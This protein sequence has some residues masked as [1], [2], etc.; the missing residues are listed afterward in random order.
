MKKTALIIGG[1]VAGISCALLLKKQNFDVHLF[2]R[3]ETLGGVT[4]YLHDS[5]FRF[6]KSAT[7][8]LFFERYAQFAAH[9]QTDLH[10]IAPYDTLD[11]TL[12]VYHASSKITLTNSRFEQIE[13][14]AKN[15]NKETSEEWNRF[16]TDYIR[17][18]NKL[19]PLIFSQ[20]FSQWKQVFSRPMLH[21]LR[22]HKPWKSVEQ[23][24]ATYNMH[25]CV[26]N[27]IR[28]IAMFNGTDL[29]KTSHLYLIF[30]AVLLDEGVL[31]FQGGLS[32]FTMRLVDLCKHANITIHTNTNVLSFLE[33]NNTVYGIKTSKKDFMGDVIIHTLDPALASTFFTQKKRIKNAL[34]IPTTSKKPHY[35]CSTFILYLGL[36]KK[37]NVST[38]S[39]IIPVTFKSS[40]KKLWQN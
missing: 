9:L 37:R 28:S 12:T 6:E 5:N 22:E 23:V 13:L 33:K 1:G 3:Q 2:E 8:S 35:S 36:K 38:H 15:F 4:G 27:I 17:L 31:H 29:S 10:T 16:L 20:S 40:I 19:E 30:P 39:L 32:A 25:E 21:F 26:K 18:K 24:L 7:L 11:T 14:F 34:H